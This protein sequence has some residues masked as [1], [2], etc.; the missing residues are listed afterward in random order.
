LL[1]AE[2]GLEFDVIMGSSIGA[3]NGA[4]YIQSRGLPDEM[5]RLCSIWLGLPAEISKIVGFTTIMRIA[6][7]ITRERDLQ[8]SLYSFFQDIIAGK[9]GLFNASPLSRLVDS[10][11]D[12]SAIGRSSRKFFIAVLES[13]IPLFDIVTSPIRSATYIDAHELN[14]WELRRA[15]LASAAIPIVF[16]RQQLRGT[17]CVDAGWTPI[18]L[19]PI[20]SVGMPNLIVTIELSDRAFSTAALD[21]ME[22]KLPILRII[23][24][25]PI[26]DGFLS[27]FN[28]RGDFIERLIRLGYGDAARALDQAAAKNIL[29]PYV[30]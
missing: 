24:S 16:P 20:L 30:Y 10:V 18:S 11:I 17:Y 29:P 21:E 15:L 22:G 1:L 2:R 23:P 25:E 8:K 19:N 27:T 28:F 7:L 14:C 4:F 5:R 26:H 3:L 12:Y 9:E 13:W 6:E